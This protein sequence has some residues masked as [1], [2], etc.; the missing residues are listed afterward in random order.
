MTLVANPERGLTRALTASHDA[1]A[2]ACSPLSE[3]AFRRLYDATSRPILAYLTAVT[4]R[5]DVADDL[6]QETYIRLL[7]RPRP[8]MDPNE[9]RRY[10]FRIATNLLRDRWRRHD[11][12]PLAELTE[13]THNPNPD[14][15]L[16][17][18]AALHHL[19]P[20]ERELLWLAYVEGMDHREIA[21]ATGLQPLSIR[22]LLYRAR[23]RAAALLNPTSV[24]RTPRP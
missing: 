21:A 15:T 19:K 17:I 24:T 13:P 23:N 14:A 5:H 18:R 6:L 22:I 16:D 11:H 20:R 7:A 4:G 2:K 8:T 12:L 1:A 3:Q 10:L 9:T